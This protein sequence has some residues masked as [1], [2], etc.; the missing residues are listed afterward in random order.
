MYSREVLFIKESLKIFIDI[1]LQRRIFSIWF[2]T[3]LFLCDLIFWLLV[4]VCKNNLFKL[5]SLSMIISILGVIYL[6]LKLPILPWNLDL[7]MVV[8]IIFYFGYWFKYKGYNFVLESSKKYLIFFIMLIINIVT[9]IINLRL[10]GKTLDLYH[11]ELANSFLSLISAI[12]GIMAVVIVSKYIEKCYILKDILKNI[13]KDSLIY[14]SLHQVIVFSLVNRIFEILNIF[15][16]DT[17]SD[18][19]FKK[20]ILFV[21]VF[22][23]L[24]PLIECMKKTK[25]KIFLGL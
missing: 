21:S 23:I 5:F 9:T 4:K 14:F 22:I 11:S 10:Y 2:I 18:K 20:L 12:S 7:S 15:N 24:K 1:L 3:C 13:G 19:L 16:K 6:K 8:I 17:P 25:L